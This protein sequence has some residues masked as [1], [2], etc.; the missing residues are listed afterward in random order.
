MRKSAIALTLTALFS[1]CSMQAEAIP[2]SYGVAT[3]S[4]AAWQELASP[5]SQYGVSWS[6]DNGA[7]WGQF[8]NLYVGQ[9]VQFMFNMHKDNVGTHY[10]DFLKSWV[11]WGKD[12]KFSESD[13]VAY[14][15]QKLSTNEGE[16]LGSWNT[17]NVPDYTFF[18]GLYTLTKDDIGDLWLRARVAC[19]ESLAASMGDS[20]WGDQWNIKD[21][22]YQSAFKPT[23]WLNQ[24]EVEEWKITVNASPVPEPATVLLL[25]SGLGVIGLRKKYLQN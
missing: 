22:V 5:T 7:T 11:D 9:Q 17:P 19:S 23:G 20:V 3:H 10:A 12:G 18:S 1:V 8:S 6:V 4:T 15:F 2:V 24:G 21:S 25:A 16:N 14:E 13:V